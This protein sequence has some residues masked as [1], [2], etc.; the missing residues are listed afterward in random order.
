M[1][2]KAKVFQHHFGIVT[3]SLISRP[4]GASPWLNKNLLSLW[5]CGKGLLQQEEKTLAVLT[6]VERTRSQ[7]LPSHSFFYVPCIILSA[8]WRKELLA[9][10]AEGWVLDVLLG[11]NL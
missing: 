1:R 7:A 3:A 10:L 2:S 5:I 6:E 9:V 11:H 8:G 4:L